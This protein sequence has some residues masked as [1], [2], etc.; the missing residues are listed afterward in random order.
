[1]V[2]GLSS[3]WRGQQSGKVVRGGNFSGNDELLYVFQPIE[4][5]ISRSATHPSYINWLMPS[6]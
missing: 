3:S 5:S 6:P 1:M 4:L 2:S